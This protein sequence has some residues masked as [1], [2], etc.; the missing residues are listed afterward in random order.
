MKDVH[1]RQHGLQGLSQGGWSFSVPMASASSYTDT[2]VMIPNNLNC[3][4]FT[5]Y[6]F[7]DPSSGQH[8]LTERRRAPLTL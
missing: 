8:S 5:N 7:S 3:S 2:F 6:M 1:R 4:D